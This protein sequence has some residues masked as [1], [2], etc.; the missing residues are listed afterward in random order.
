M[1]GR[2]LNFTGTSN[3]TAAAFRDLRRQ[4]TAHAALDVFHNFSSHLVTDVLA[5]HRLTTRSS[6]RRV[7]RADS[8]AGPKI[9]A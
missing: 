6:Q 3:K 9:P 5:L 1:P 7:A 8:R 2:A 4:S